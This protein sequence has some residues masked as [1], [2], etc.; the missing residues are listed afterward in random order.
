MAPENLAEF[1]KYQVMI[2]K[3]MIPIRGFIISNEMIYA[4]RSKL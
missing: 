2:E 1:K 4:G 3:L